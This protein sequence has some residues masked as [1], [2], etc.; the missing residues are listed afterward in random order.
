MSEC[1]YNVPS[2]AARVW[3]QNNTHLKIAESVARSSAIES[4]GNV[5]TSDGGVSDHQSSVSTGVSMVSQ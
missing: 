2:A 1:I 5:E 3:L 4:R